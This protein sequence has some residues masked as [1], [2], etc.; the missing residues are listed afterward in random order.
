MIITSP[1]SP[2]QKVEFAYAFD[3]HTN[4]YFLQFLINWIIILFFKP[5]LDYDNYITKQ[6]G[7]TFYLTSWI[8]YWYLTFLGYQ[9]LPF[10]KN[11]TIFLV[12]IVIGIV[13]WLIGLFGIIDIYK[14]MTKLYYN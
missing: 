9:V 6:L 2:I 13:I 11:T 4:G 1:H 3:I 14:L 12:P 7:N 8:M 5:L 10:L